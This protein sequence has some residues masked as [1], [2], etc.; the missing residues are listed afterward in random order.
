MGFQ[1]KKAGMISFYQKNKK[2][3]SRFLKFFSY[4]VQVLAI[5][6]LWVSLKK[7]ND[8]FINYL[9]KYDSGLLVFFASSL[10][11]ACVL[12][13]PVLGWAKL[14][15]FY[16]R[17]SISIIE[18]WWLYCRTAV[19]KYVPGNVFHYIS[20]QFQGANFGWEQ[21]AMGLSSAMEAAFVI[22]AGGL[23]TLLAFP[24]IDIPE[25]VIPLKKEYFLLFVSG[26]FLF[27]FLIL[28]VLNRFLREKIKDFKLSDIFTSN[29]FLSYFSYILFLIASAFLFS[30]V[31]YFSNLPP[32]ASAYG[33]FI[34]GFV[35]T[36]AYI[37]PGA[38]GG[39]GVREALIALSF[40]SYGYES[41]AAMAAII[42]R[43]I[44]VIGEF[45]CFVS[46]FV[47]VPRFSEK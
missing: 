37:T 4:M 2:E 36:I 16:S 5:Y 44:T 18:C 33:I 35:Y 43:L 20:R 30:A 45:I 27:P 46:T 15:E 21:K 47:L 26:M 32:A 25:N 29:I 39:I 42:F 13:L 38:P 41:E 9:D 22:S 14:L 31:L 28:Y 23:F 24:F 34:Y 10:L 12:F 6:Y 3:F 40:S 7:N 19:F 1:Q 8:I 11:Y 17:H